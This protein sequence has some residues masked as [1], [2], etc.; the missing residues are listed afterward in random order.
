M[1]L[2]TAVVG[3]G[4][5]S[6]IHLSGLDKNPR[7]KL[8]AVCD[9]DEE[10]AHSAAADYG[11][12]AYTDL[13]TMLAEEDLDW[14]HICTSVQSHLPLARM[15]I[16]AGVPVQI[17]KPIT[18]TSEEFEELEALSKRH[19]VLVSS[20]HQHVFD[21]AMRRAMRRIESGELGKIRG[22]DVLYA[23]EPGPSEKL[24]GSW[25]GEL[26]G[27]EFEEGIP[28]P[29]YLTLRAGGYPRSRD[30]I[31][32]TTGLV[33]NHVGF[34]YDTALVQYT[35]EN[36]VPCTITM[37]SDAAPQQLIHIHGD[38]GSMTV[39]LISQTV[40]NVGLNYNG[41]PIAKVRNNVRRATDRL[42]GTVKNVVLVG[43]RKMND[44][45]ET[46]RT[47][48]SHYYQFDAEAKAIAVGGESP[49][50]LDQAKWTIEI[51]EAI[52]EEATGDRPKTSAGELS[53]VDS[54]SRA[55]GE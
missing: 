17:E 4:V 6:G 41:S 43:R 8:V 28:H 18:E 13:E 30:D 35:S 47:V 2:N 39:D 38:R 48:D 36:G 12:R 26:P 27:G 54:L 11:I 3:A 9:L 10:R 21:P 45:W 1:V 55:D 23:G 14:L 7:T 32:V 22:V 50:P 53:H 40:Q 25:A 19:G 24:R 29:I 5:V 31:A 46:D 15:A 16:E 49:V 44:D 42:V 20:V 51:M 34:D 37:R 52:R 33:D